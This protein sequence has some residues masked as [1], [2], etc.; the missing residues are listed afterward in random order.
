MSECCD[1]R[2][3]SISLGLLGA[4]LG[5][6]IVNN[7]IEPQKLSNMKIEAIINETKMKLEKGKTVGT[8]TIPPDEKPPKSKQK[9]QTSDDGKTILNEATFGPMTQPSQPPQTSAPQSS[10]RILDNF[11]FT[12]DSLITY[13]I[14]TA[15]ILFYNYFGNVMP[16]TNFYQILFGL[17]ATSKQIPYVRRMFMLKSIF[18]LDD[19]GLM[20]NLNK[21]VKKKYEDL[22]KKINDTY[23]KFKPKKKPKKPFFN[24]DIKGKE[25]QFILLSNDDRELL[26]DRL[27]ILEGKQEAEEESELRITGIDTEVEM[28]NFK[29]INRE[30]KAKGLNELT[31]MQFRMLSLSASSYS[32]LLTSGLT[33]EKALSMA[34]E[35]YKT[36]MEKTNKLKQI[37]YSELDLQKL[38]QLREQNKR[39]LETIDQLETVSDNISI[40]TADLINTY[41]NVIH[42]ISQSINNGNI[43]FAYSFIK[44]TIGSLKGKLNTVKKNMRILKN[45]QQDTTGLEYLEE[46]HNEYIQILNLFNEKLKLLIDM[47]KIELEKYKNEKLDALFGKA[48]NLRKSVSKYLETLKYRYENPK[49]TEEQKTEYN[50]LKFQLYTMIYKKHKTLFNKRTTSKSNAT[51]AKNN[52]DNY[53]KQLG[54]K[55]K[56]TDEMMKKLAQLKKKMEKTQKIKENIEK[57]YTE[58]VNEIKII[59]DNN[60]GKNI[61]L[62]KSFMLGKLF[63]MTSYQVTIS[64]EDMKN[65]LELIKELKQKIGDDID[66]LTRLLLQNLL[67]ISDEQ[68]EELQ[69][70][71]SDSAKLI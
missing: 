47:F 43:S 3:L 37:D 45:N 58:I 31:M 59:I 27:D 9:P 5:A 53:L 32:S 19:K 35:I 71:F 60:F 22:I 42:I 2:N 68:V 39:T 54:N 23:K 48:T 18:K 41:N 57:K 67:D 51:R 15:Q 65:L 62:L 24:S 52:Y 33:K 10:T 17:I 11:T 56:L 26:Q 70:Q 63:F 69:K 36:Y 49:M 44:D 4:Y 13:G 29:Q 8:G 55:K 16:I 38:I 25:E 1:N 30:R 61:N 28:E 21:F 34:S 64:K 12:N 66:D 20:D 6:G 14:V 46:L 7:Y 50:K 40:R